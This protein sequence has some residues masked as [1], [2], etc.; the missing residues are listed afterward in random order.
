[1]LNDPAA[2]GLES[3]ENFSAQA[4][5][6][7]ETR[8]E[9]RILAERYAYVR[10]KVRTSQGRLYPSGRVLLVLPGQAPYLGG[11]ED[12]DELR[13]SRDM[14]TTHMPHRYVLALQDAE[15]AFP[16]AG[17]KVHSVITGSA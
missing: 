5:L 7:L 16:R 8:G 2:G 10:P 15:A 14:F 17:A 9:H 3:P 11:L 1:M 12:V 4:L 6:D 13:I